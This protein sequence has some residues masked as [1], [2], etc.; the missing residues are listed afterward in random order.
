MTCDFSSLLVAFYHLFIMQGTAA[1]FNKFSRRGNRCFVEHSRLSF[2]IG[3]SFCFYL[4]GWGLLTYAMLQ[5]LH[6][7]EDVLIPDICQKPVSLKLL[8]LIIR[9]KNLPLSPTVVRH[10]NGAWVLVANNKGCIWQGL[11]TRNE[12]V[13]EGMDSAS[14]SEAGVGLEHSGQLRVQWYMVPGSNIFIPHPQIKSL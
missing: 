6:F 9:L 13:A 1:S 8:R 10:F 4:Y 11:L 5:V 7:A 3:C 12:E 14:Y 2:E